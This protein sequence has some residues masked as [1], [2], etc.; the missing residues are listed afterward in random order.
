MLGVEDMM[1]RSQDN[2]FI[3]PAIA[4]DVVGVEQFVI[5][6]RQSEIIQTSDGVGIRDK[7]YWWS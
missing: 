3:G 7:R 1:H 4:G 2:V 5:I 6:G